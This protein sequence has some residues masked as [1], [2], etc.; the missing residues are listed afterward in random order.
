MTVIIG[1]CFS[2]ISERRRAALYH[3]EM[4]GGGERKPGTEV[5]GSGEAVGDGSVYCCYSWGRFTLS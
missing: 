5:A 2:I 1:G 3:F 4:W